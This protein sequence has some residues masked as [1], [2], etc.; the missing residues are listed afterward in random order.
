MAKPM[1]LNQAHKG[2]R[3]KNVSCKIFPLLATL[4]VGNERK[5]LKYI[6]ET[7]EKVWNI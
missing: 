6:K 5:S 2:F 4:S 7:R 3:G 1:R